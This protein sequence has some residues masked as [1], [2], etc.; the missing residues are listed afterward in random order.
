MKRTI[1][2]VFDVNSTLDTVN[3][4]LSTIKG[5]SGW[6]TKDVSGSAAL[7]DTIDFKFGAVFNP[8][9]KVL[10][11]GKNKIQWE[12][13][14]GE[15]AWAGDKFSFIMEETKSM[16]KVT[17]TQEYSNEIN[18]EQ[19]GRFNFNWGYYMNSLKQYCE[20][21]KGAPYTSK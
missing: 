9:M 4:S 10:Q 6:W 3:N 18:D 21:G 2:H 7:G 17:F 1:L 13:I 11:S 15:K 12:C 8:L 20:T 5:L 19:Y 14:G 16:I